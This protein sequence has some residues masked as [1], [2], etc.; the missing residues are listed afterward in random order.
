MSHSQFHCTGRVYLDLHG[1]IFETSICYWQDQPGRQK[2]PPP[3]RPS[4]P[5]DPR[6]EEEATA[7]GG[8]RRLRRRDATRGRSAER[9]QPAAGRS[10]GGEKRGARRRE[11]G[12]RGESVP[13]PLI[14]GSAGGR[15][16]ARSLARSLFSWAPSRPQNVRTCAPPPPLLARRVGAGKDASRSRSPA[17]DRG[18]PFFPS[19]EEEEERVRG[20]ETSRETWLSKRRA[21][22]SRRRR[23]L[24]LGGRGSGRQAGAPASDAVGPL[25]LTVPLGLAGLR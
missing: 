2:S 19:P 18:F 5:T 15:A 20:L 10:G 4:E 16:P 6:G 9:E 8:R 14:P 1:L 11:W 24:R 21:A 7:A 22:R 25:S 23:Y 13:S 3:R 12:G 17:G